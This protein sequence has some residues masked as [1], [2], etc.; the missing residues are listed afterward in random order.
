MHFL[1]FVAEWTVGKRQKMFREKKKNTNN[2]RE[3][4][5]S[6]FFFFFPSSRRQASSSLAEKRFV[7]MQGPASGSLAL[8]LSLSLSLSHFFFFF[9]FFFKKKKRDWGCFGYIRF[10]INL[11]RPSEHHNSFYSAL[12]AF[13]GVCGRVDG[14]WK[15]D[16]YS[17]KEKT[18]KT[19]AELKHLFF[20]FPPSSRRQASSSLA[21]K[22]FVVMQGSASGSL[23]LSLSFFFWKI[24]LPFNAMLTLNNFRFSASA[25]T[26]GSCG[27]S[28][29]NTKRRFACLTRCKGRV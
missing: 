6:S 4:Q 29:W 7:V 23:S 5:T 14:W 18:L 12:H 27:L 24:I 17:E 21:E 8:S 26:S 16:K 22:R 1:A 2:T 25:T 19:R 20:F 11:F 15:R 28:T 9:I 13:F 10:S 3:T